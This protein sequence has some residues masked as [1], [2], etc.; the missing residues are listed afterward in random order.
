M[1][2]MQAV[3]PKH[4][5]VFADNGALDYLHMGQI[6]LFCCKYLTFG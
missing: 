4:I 6:R 5:D 1:V 2:S 3:F